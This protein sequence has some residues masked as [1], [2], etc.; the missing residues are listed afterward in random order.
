MCHLRIS[1]L[2][3]SLD[4]EFITYDCYSKAK[5]SWLFSDL[6]NNIT[7]T[8]ADS[9]KKNGTILHF[10]PYGRNDCKSTEENMNL[11]K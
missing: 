8:L 11:H 5:L 6:D 1:N 9:W 2:R 7:V 3:E 4:I 10:E